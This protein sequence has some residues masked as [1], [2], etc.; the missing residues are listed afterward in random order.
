MNKIM[1]GVLNKNKKLNFPIYTMC[2][3]WQHESQKPKTLCKQRPIYNF[4]LHQEQPTTAC[5][6]WSESV[7]HASDQSL[8]LL[9]Y[10]LHH[11]R[12]R[13]SSPSDGCVFLSRGEGGGGGI[14]QQMRCW[15]VSTLVS[16]VASSGSRR[17]G[18]RA[19]RARPA[20]PGSSR[21][22]LLRLWSVC[23]VLYRRWSL[24]RMAVLLQ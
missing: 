15:G 6:L 2:Q 16:V 1:K 4:T 12:P 18:W 10:H 9:L 8:F 13:P 21:T 17:A 11:Q 24:R 5:I 14:S 19:R 20:Q 22:Q 3:N 7:H 23:T